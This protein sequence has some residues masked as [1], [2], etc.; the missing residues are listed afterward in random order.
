[1]SIKIVTD[2]TS[3]LTK[4]LREDL[5]ISVVSLSINI[6]DQSFLEEEMDPVSFFHQIEK[7]PTIPAS[8]QPGIQDIYDIFEKRIVEGHGVVGIFLSSEMSG[9]YSTAITAKNMIRENYPESKIEIIDSRSNCMQ[10]GFIALAAARW[11]QKEASMEQ[12]LIAAQEVLEKSRFI[13]IPQTL[14]YLKKGG[15]IGGASHLLGTILKIKPILTVNEGKVAVINK[16]RTSE[17]AVQEILRIFCEDVQQ[18]GLGEGVVHH[19]NNEHG[20]RAIAEKIADH[21]GVSLPVS[22]IGPVIGAH[23][24]PGAVGIAYYT[25][26]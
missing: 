23:V 22:P 25:N 18:K 19:I 21:L 12:V 5:D 1:M 2:S 6:G 7:Y 9:T 14:N 8:S 15:R 10:L 4:Q 3:Y 17:K 26:K 11:A 24:G 13:F 20:A 16:I